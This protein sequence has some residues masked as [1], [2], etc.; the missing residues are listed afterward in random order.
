MSISHVIQMGL[1]GKFSKTVSDLSPTVFWKLN[2]AVGTI[3]YDTTSNDFD[4]TYVGTPTQGVAGLVPEGTAGVSLNGTT[5]YV[6][7][8]DQAT[9]D[10]G[11]GSV[12]IVALVKTSTS[13]DSYLACK[14]AT[15]SVV[16]YSVEVTS[17]GKIRVGGDNVTTLT[18]TIS[19]NNGSWRLVVCVLDRT[20]NLYRVYIDGTADGTAALSAAV[21]LDNDRALRVGASGDD[22]PAAFLS[23]SVSCVAVFV[24][25]ILS[26]ANVTTLWNA[27]QWT[28][29]SA[30]VFEGVECAYGMQEA[31]PEVRIATS[32]ELKFRLDNSASNSGGLLG[33]YSLLNTNKRSGFDL[34]IPVRWAI[35]NGATTYYKFYG[36]LAECIPDPGQYRDRVVKCVALDWMDEASRLKVSGLDVQTSKRSDELIGLLLNSMT[37]RPSQYSIETGRETYQYAFDSLKDEGT[38]VREE[39]NRIASSEL[40]YVYVKGDTTF[41]G[42][43]IF[44]NRSH[45]ASNPTTIV[46]LSNVQ[47]GMTVPGSRDEIVQKVL[48]S[49]KPVSVDAAATTVLFSLQTTE[50]LVRA[51]ATNSTI[52]GPYRDPSNPGTRIG[53]ISQ[54]TPVATTDYTMNTASDG[55]GSDLTVDFTV[56]ASFTGNGVRFT[57]VNNGTTDGYITKLQVRG[58]GV[59][60]YTAV[61][62]RTINNVYGQRT[63]SAEMPYQNNINTGDDVASYWA[64]IYSA[65]LS[66]ARFVSFFGNRTASMMTH[67]LAR[68]PGDRIALTETVTGLSSSEFT[69]NG[70]GINIVGRGSDP[71]L[72]CTWYLEPGGT[73][74][75]WLLGTAGASELGSTTV[76]GF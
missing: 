42:L 23:G 19:V 35:T 70:V 57:I 24:G 74:D 61:L 21:N 33:Y 40:G 5:Q 55:S 31:G 41:G 66:H 18:S 43:F 34:N 44:E 30:D 54:V 32:G 10:V 28:D 2:E 56:T 47:V 69:I 62:E 9:F 46:T 64:Q 60:R 52:F 15:G 26:Q 6:T 71:Q 16:G 75:F 59:Y 39:L 76:L 8:A 63:L 29:V 27:A 49:V 12:S 65:P 36:K 67:A 45:R 68:E 51:G 17:A 38:A 11:L 1:G 22:T 4:G 7:R 37:D 3:A 50:T 13:S 14:R 73:Q 25:T 58:K 20:S 72:L 53:A 48:V